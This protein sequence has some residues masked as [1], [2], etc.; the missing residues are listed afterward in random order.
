MKPLQYLNLGT[1]LMAVVVLLSVVQTLRG[2]GK[3]PTPIY[4]KLLILLAVAF[5]VYGTVR[6]IR[7]RNNP[8]K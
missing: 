5:Q 3:L 2:Y 7:E 4:I 1:A 6:Y 8:N